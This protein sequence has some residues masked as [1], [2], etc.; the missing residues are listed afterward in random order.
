MRAYMGEKVHQGTSRVSEKGMSGLLA[1]A[2]SR[3]IKASHRRRWKATA[4]HT[5]Y[6][7]NNPYTFT[8]P[9]GRETAMF[10]SDQYRM[11]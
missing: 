7:N 5:R 10:Q 4:G 3:Y 11:A 1:S 2:K 6:A 8:D 9:D